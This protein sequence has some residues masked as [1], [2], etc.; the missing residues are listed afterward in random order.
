MTLY[1]VCAIYKGDTCDYPLVRSYIRAND[2][3]P[4]TLWAMQNEKKPRRADRIEVR[5]IGLFDRFLIW[6]NLLP[7]RDIASSKQ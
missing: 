5:Q 3:R 6:L 2:F 7:V 1:S 4:A